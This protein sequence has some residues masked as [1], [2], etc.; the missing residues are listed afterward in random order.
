MSL[1]PPMISKKCSAGKPIRLFTEVFFV[2][3]K[4]AI[5]RVGPAKSECKAIRAGS[6]FWSSITKRR[7]N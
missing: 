7:I 6:K 2:K 1:R 5:R 4:T 3:I